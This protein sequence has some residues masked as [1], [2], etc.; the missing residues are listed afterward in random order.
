MTNHESDLP[1]G[2]LDPFDE[3]VELG[4]GPDDV[5]LMRT[6]SATARIVSSLIDLFFIGTFII[7]PSTII[8]LVVLHP[9]KG[10]KFTAAQ[11]TTIW[12]ISLVVTVLVYLACVAVERRGAGMP[13]RRLLR[14][15]LVTLGG[16]RPTVGRLL[17][18]FA[19]LLFVAI[20]PTFAVVLLLAILTPALQRDR[21][22]GLDLLAGTRV[23][24]APAS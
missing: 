16:N 2:P 5:P 15:R 12:V 8:P 23:I 13:G 10:Q 22:D 19:P 9:V 14:L 1:E 6:P 18:R 7:V 17:L 4:S 24:G 20:I 11:N 21:R 3:G